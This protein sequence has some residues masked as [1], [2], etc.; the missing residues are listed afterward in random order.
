[1][2]LIADKLNLLRDFCRREGLD[3]G[4]YLLRYRRRAFSDAEFD[5]FEIFRGLMMNRLTGES[6]AYVE[7]KLNISHRDKRSAVEYGADLVLS[8]LI[9][10]VVAEVFGLRLTGSDSGREF[11]SAGEITN[12]TDFMLGT[13]PVELMVDWGSYWV[14][15]GRIHFRHDKLLKLTEKKAVVLGFAIRCNSFFVMDLENG[16]HYRKEYNHRQGKHCALVENYNAFM[17]M[18]EAREALKRMEK[19]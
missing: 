9:E 17:N 12:S 18:A 14:D 13:R 6:L 1:M 11:L 5:K 15:L 4:H 10:D 19:K 8:W 7:R 16:I 2:S 3:L